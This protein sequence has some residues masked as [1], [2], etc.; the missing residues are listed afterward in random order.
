[1]VLVG[2]GLAPVRRGQP[3]PLHPAGSV[4]VSGAADLVENSEGGAVFIWGMAAACWDAGDVVA[5]RF[6]AVQLVLTGA[7]TEVE[8]ASAF[9]AGEASVQRWIAAFRRGG[10]AALAP[11]RRGPKGPWKLT[12][13]MEA[14]I[15]ELR[16]GG[17]SKGAIAAAV[18]VSPDTVSRVLVEPTP[19]SVGPATT[20]Q[21]EDD[22][23]ELV[24]LARPE[25]R[26]AERQAARRG[27]LAEAR[28]DITAGASLPLAGALVILPALAVTGLLACFEETYGR[29][30]AA[31][32]GLRSLVLT[33]VFAT[34]VGEPRAEGLT[35]IDPVDVGRL[36]GLDRAPEPKTLRR[37]MAAL[38]KRS[39]ADRLLGALARRHADAHS[40]ALGVLYVDGHVRAYHG[41]ANVPK[42][43]VA[44]MRL[45]MPAEVDTWVA[46]RNGD[47]LLVVSAPPGAS[48]VAE[49][50]RVTAWAREIV[51]PDRRPTIGFD[52]GGWSPALFAEL[53]R[54]GFDILTYRKGPKRPEP[55]RA[56][57]EDSFVDDAERTHTYLAH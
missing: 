6:A 22:G 47:G 16:Q 3:L 29:A 12:E 11:A 7:A 56:F 18:G 57:S 37:R 4:R 45:S 43:H 51:G 49:L 39:L 15:R 55:R 26:D 5:R 13:E 35:R 9:G 23:T 40:D 52:R 28:P 1:M 17:A 25:R 27:D 42:A 44:R 20:P 50:R 34:L 2:A 54:A 33:V 8:V 41:G 53:R 10:V 38:A 46:D 14:A 30:K 31:F 48:L 21:P 19:R 24:A 32:Y 36:L